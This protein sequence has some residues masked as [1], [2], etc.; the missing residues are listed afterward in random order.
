MPEHLL[1]VLLLDPLFLGT[2][3]YYC[4]VESVKDK[5]MIQLDETETVPSEVDDYTPE[6]S[7][8]MIGLYHIAAHMLYIVRQTLLMCRIWLLRCYRSRNLGPLICLT[9]RLAIRQQNL[10]AR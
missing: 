8:L 5:L 1:Y 7:E 10:S 2:L 9:M 4:D 6:P 3:A